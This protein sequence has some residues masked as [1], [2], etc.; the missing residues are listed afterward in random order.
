[1]TSCTHTPTGVVT[2]HPE[3][4]GAPD[5][6]SHATAPVCDLPECIQEATEWVQRMTYGKPAHYIRSATAA[7]REAA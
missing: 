5:G 1:M 2:T 6:S 7:Q 4:F 3:P